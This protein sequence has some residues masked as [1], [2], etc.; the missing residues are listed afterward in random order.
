MPAFMYCRLSPEPGW[1]QSTTVSET[2]RDRGL[3]LA[4]AHGLDDHLIV[5]RAHQDHRRGRQRGQSAQ[6]PA[7]RH[8]A[9]EHALILGSELDAGAIAEQGAAAPARRRI[10][11]DHA[12]RAATPAIALDHARQEGRF[13][14][15]RRARHADDMGPRA[16]IGGIEQRERLR[17]AGGRLEARQR[18]RHRAL[19]AG[20]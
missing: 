8:R 20:P 2:R 3:R 16:G 7:G 4:D 11:G 14:D 10:D 17:L 15:P 5:D 12:D 6:A 18:D 13:A 19:A 1:M 9:D